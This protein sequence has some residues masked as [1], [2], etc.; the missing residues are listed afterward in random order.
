MHAQKAVIITDTNVFKYYKN[1]F[2]DCDIITINTG[3]K[4]KNLDTVRYIYGKLLDFEV[5]RSSFLIGIGGGIVC[6]ITGFVASTYLRGI[7]FGF[8]ASTLL[9]QVDASVGGKNGVNYKGYKNIIGVFNQP[10]F[11]I[12]DINMLNTLPQEEILCGIA[13]I[14]KHAAIE[15]SDYFAYIEK[16]SRHALTLDLDIMEKLVFDSVLIKSVIVNKDEHEKGE[17]RKLNFGH[18]FGHAYEKIIGAPHGEAVSA[19]MVMAALISLKMGKLSLT[20]AE[21][22]VSLIEKFNLRTGFQTETN[23]LIDVLGKDK[24]REG[25]GIHFVLL[26]EIGNAFVEKISIRKLAKMVN[27]IQS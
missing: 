11:V 21:R 19:G 26:N 17:R 10:E 9:A 5:D 12:C 4:I 27:D 24:K 6:D 15:S 2:P 8:V 7:R 14:I 23:Y 1:N 16:N 25:E 20:D 18:T 3:E 13:E 22:I